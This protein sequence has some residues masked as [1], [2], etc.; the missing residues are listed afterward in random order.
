[1]DNEKLN[2]ALKRFG[3]KHGDTEAMRLQKSVELVV[4]GAPLE[5]W[6]EVLFAGGA[7][8]LCDRLTALDTSAL[9]S[10]ALLDALANDEN[11]RVG[12]SGWELMRHWKVAI[13]AWA[14]TDG[15]NIV[16]D[17]ARHVAEYNRWLRILVHEE[18]VSYYFGH[19]EHKRDVEQAMR[20]AATAHVCDAHAVGA[21]FS[22]VADIGQVRELFAKI[23]EL[24]DTMG[25]QTFMA[26]VRIAYAA[27]SEA[28]YGHDL[29][30]FEGV[31][32]DIEARQ[33]GPRYLTDYHQRLIDPED[34]A[35]QLAAGNT[36]PPQM[37]QEF[38]A[39]TM[40]PL[41]ADEARVVIVQSVVNI[42]SNHNAFSARITDEEIERI[43]E[44]VAQASPSVL[45]KVV[46]DIKN[47]FI[48]FSVS[49]LL[50][51]LFG[52]G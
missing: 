21:Y 37:A 28:G 42:Q 30:K 35:L 1:M 24:P 2:Q 36:S 17:P 27:A 45:A 43:K 9:T 18:L 12:Q 50:G 20:D 41:G 52:G 48:S 16:I 31:A 23:A 25:L 33:R 26:A 19:I 11:H 7:E 5:G 10:G 13:H 3:A 4:R 39:G 34:T 49:K 22:Q 38:Q 47:W 44:G 15:S 6:N 14:N 8:R 51:M 46:N 29:R 40:L 32:R